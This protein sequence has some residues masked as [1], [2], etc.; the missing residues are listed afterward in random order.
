MHS[1]HLAALYFILIFLLTCHKSFHLTNK[2]NQQPVKKIMNFLN[3]QSP[4]RKQWRCILGR[5]TQ[6]SMTD[7][8]Y[9][10]KPEA[11]T[12]SRRYVGQRLNPDI[13]MVLHALGLSSEV[14]S[15]VVFRVQ[16]LTCSCSLE[17]SSRDWSRT[18]DPALPSSLSPV[19]GMGKKR[20]IICKL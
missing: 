5:T 2:N 11:A 17:A 20:K 4:H 3:D 16:S 10:C 6:L 14:I 12:G 19:E 15:L 8:T 13:N 7:T 18:R 9:S 1:F